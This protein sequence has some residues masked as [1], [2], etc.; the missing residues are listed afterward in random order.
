LNAHQTQNKNDISYRY[1]KVSIQN[2]IEDGMM[3]AIDA[4]DSSNTNVMQM[5]MYLTHRNSKVNLSIS[6]VKDT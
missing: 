1:K 5:A 6:K 2:K 3:K 4:S